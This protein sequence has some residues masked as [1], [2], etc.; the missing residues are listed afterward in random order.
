MN[1]AE[2][3]YWNASRSKYGIWLV[4]G[5]VLLSVV[6]CLVISLSGKGYGMGAPV[7][8]PLFFCL[9]GILQFFILEK[10]YKKGLSRTNLYLVLKTIKLL[11]SIILVIVYGLFSRKDIVM[12]SLLLIVFYLINLIL[13]T[14][15]FVEFEKG[16]KK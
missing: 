1:K 5:N 12:F 3:E 7:C 15:F 16:Y 14:L 4:S 8:I 6:S 2:R 11:V 9:L 10:G 13:D